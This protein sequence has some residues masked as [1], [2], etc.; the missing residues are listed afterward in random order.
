V[1]IAV[2]DTIDKIRKRWPDYTEA[3]ILEELASAFTEMLKDV[4][5]VHETLTLASIVSGTS[6][7]AIAG[8][9]KIWTARWEPSSDS[10]GWIPLLATSIK[11][12]ER[13]TP[14]FRVPPSQS[15]STPTHY[16]I[17]T[18]ITGTG[19]KSL[20]LWP[21]PT[22]ASSSGYPRVRLEVTKP[23]TVSKTGYWPETLD[24]D[25]ALVAAVC[26]ER[27]AQLGKTEDERYWSDKKDKEV[28]KM[29]EMFEYQA[30][31]YNPKYQHAP[32]QIGRR[33]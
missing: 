21:I 24:T 14:D 17:D 30:N 32:E 29:R 22:V 15:G 16:Y 19:A 9:I 12:L 5:L 11:V 2:Q 23:W 20:G 31:E 26:E 4:R 10:S 28:G 6:P 3:E 27:S 8:V 25:S 33:V 18:P 1:A 13:D 7:Y